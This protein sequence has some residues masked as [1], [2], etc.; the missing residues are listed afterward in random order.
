MD[1]KVA[2]I[3]GN[4]R[5]GMSSEEIDL[6]S[7]T[8]NIQT[9][10][11]LQ[12]QRNVSTSSSSLNLSHAGVIFFY[13]IFSHCKEREGHFRSV[14][15]QS[16][17]QKHRPLDYNT[18]TRLR[19]VLVQSRRLLDVNLSDV[20]EEGDDDDDV[21]ENLTGLIARNQLSAKDASVLFSIGQ[22]VIALGR[23]RSLQ[24]KGEEGPTR[25]KEKEPSILEPALVEALEGALESSH[26]HEEA[27]EGLE[28]VEQ[29][30]ELVK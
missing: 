5:F 25:R 19:D 13:E 4:E 2:V 27:G 8:I 28:S 17:R 26:S 12:K 6:C 22:R 3:L 10:A 21:Y 18:K 14:P 16:T 23:L 24:L 29:I 1:V 7:H 9:D 20:E 11:P 15:E 30:K